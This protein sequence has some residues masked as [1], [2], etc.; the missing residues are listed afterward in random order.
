MLLK[1][2][3]KQIQ[4]SWYSAAVSKLPESSLFFPL[5]D[6]SQGFQAKGKTK[7]DNV[8]MPTMGMLLPFKIDL[9]M[10]RGASPDQAC[11]MVG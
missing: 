1:A 6:I 4:P 8:L 2:G 9:K 11:S 7:H 10:L 3:Q 5:P